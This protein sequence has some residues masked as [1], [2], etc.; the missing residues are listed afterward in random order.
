MTDEEIGEMLEGLCDLFTLR[1]LK[2][3]DKML[4]EI[5]YFTACKQKV[6][7]I[8]LDAL[9]EYKK[10]RGNIKPLWAACMQEN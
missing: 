10:L 3:R 5:A 9:I 2:N 7:P 6:L 1:Q 4:K 8:I